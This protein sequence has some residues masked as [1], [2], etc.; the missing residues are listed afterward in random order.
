MSLIKAIRNAMADK[1]GAV[2]VDW[3]V[4]TAAVVVL[5]IGA[6]A[7]LDGGITDMITSI[8]DELSFSNV[9]S[10]AQAPE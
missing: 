9:E 8:N 2:T 6:I 3:V 4:L 1:C 5:S 7:A 10:Q